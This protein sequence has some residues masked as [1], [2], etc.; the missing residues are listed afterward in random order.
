MIKFDRYKDNLR[1]LDDSIYSYNTEV[2]HIDDTHRRV[3]ELG[4]WSRTTRKHVRY[5]AD[6]YGYEL[7]KYLEE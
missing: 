4:Y 3:Y 1:Q 2:A 6:H 7:V 5:V